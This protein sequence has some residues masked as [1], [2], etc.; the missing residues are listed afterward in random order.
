MVISGLKS[1]E[2]SL[3]MIARTTGFSEH[4]L[5]FSWVSIKELSMQ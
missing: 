4:P 3:I 5:F 1:S 2:N